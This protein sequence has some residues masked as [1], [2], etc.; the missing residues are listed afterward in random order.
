MLQALHREQGYLVE[1]IVHQQGTETGQ[2]SVPLKLQRKM[3]LETTDNRP[4]L[5]KFNSAGS[6]LAYLYLKKESWVTCCTTGLVSVT[7]LCF[8]AVAS[9]KSHFTVTNC[10]VLVLA[11]R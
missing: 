1:W 4:N 6:I 3:R 7:D 8:N 5:T 2:L 10:D 11:Y 9:E